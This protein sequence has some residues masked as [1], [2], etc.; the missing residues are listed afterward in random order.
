MIEPREFLRAWLQANTD[1]D[2]KGIERILELYD[3]S[4]LD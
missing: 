1:Y 4:P 2:E 3:E